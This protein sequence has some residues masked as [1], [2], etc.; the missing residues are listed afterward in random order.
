MRRQGECVDDTGICDGCRGQLEILRSCT[1]PRCS[2]RVERG[3]S[4]RGDGGWVDGG[5]EAVRAKL[6]LA[7]G[8]GRETVDGQDRNGGVGAGN[9]DGVLIYL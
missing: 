4:E 8:R 1:V 9:G 7:V 3:E 5:K 2:W 6:D